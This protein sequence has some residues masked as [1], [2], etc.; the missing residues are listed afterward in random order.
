MFSR[1]LLATACVFASV[2]FA[3]I[4]VAFGGSINLARDG[5][6][7]HVIV[8]AD[9]A[10]AAEKTAAKELQDHLKQ[11]TGV[12]LDIVNESDLVGGDAP[13]ILVGQTKLARQLLPDVKW[14]ALGHDGIL[15]KS[16]GG[17]IVL[18][19]G[20]PRGTLYAVNTFLEDVVGVRWWTSGESTVP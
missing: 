9:D 3:S 2:V 11:V 10:I 5:K 17:K 12:T 8:T 13:Q 6:S 1:H 16:I 15:L 19:G 4:A 20:R 18:A 14:D 7:A